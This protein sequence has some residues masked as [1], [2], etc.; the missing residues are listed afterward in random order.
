MGWEAGRC[1]KTSTPRGIFIVIPPLE[2]WP[3][4][5]IEAP[6]PHEEILAPLDTNPVF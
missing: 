6:S 4:K 2:G 3:T 5:A 1:S